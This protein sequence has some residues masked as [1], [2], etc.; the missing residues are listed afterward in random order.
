[1]S[2]LTRSFAALR[3]AAA[4]RLSRVADGLAARLACMG[5]RPARR[6]RTVD[7]LTP[8]DAAAA[9]RRAG[10]D[11]RAEGVR[12][13]LDGLSPL[14]A[15]EGRR[16]DALHALGWLDDM[17]AADPTARRALAATAFDWLRRHGDGGAGW[18]PDLAGRRLGALAAAWP[19]LDAQGDA[20]DRRRL[21]RAIDAHLRFLLRRAAAADAPLRRLEAAAGLT[22]GAVAAGEDAHARRGAALAGAAADALIDREGGAADRSPETLARA[23]ALAAWATEALQAAGVDPEPRL[24]AALGRAAPALRALRMGDGGLPRL[25][26]AARAADALADEALARAGAIGRGLRRAEAAGCAR[27]AAGRTIAILDAAPPP[28]G[29]AGCA[30]TLALEVSVGRTR[31][32]G[33]IGTGRAMSADWATAARATAAHSAVEVAGASSARLAPDGWA[34]RILGRPLV[35]G[36][37]AAQAER[38]EDLDGRWLL[39][40]HDGYLRRFGVVVARRLF[41]SPDGRDLRGED[42]LSCPDATARAAFQR[43]AKNGELPFCVRFHLGPGVAAE[44]TGGAVALR[45]P[46]GARWRV[47]CS[48]GQ[49]EVADSVR[50]DAGEP[51]PAALQVVATSRARDYWGRVI[52]RFREV[53][54]APRASPAADGRRRREPPP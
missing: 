43:A 49:L 30:S 17:L 9:A 46:D 36:P 18:R 41:L 23:A 38:V 28:P 45:L 48:G 54:P 26:G 20:A 31:L 13:R 12:G 53:E 21:A 52:W 50:L 6:A 35:A 39:A 8:G 5:A 51:P 11:W 10:G 16:A 25:H 15:A 37:T 47:E 34:A 3:R 14:A 44:R 22:V 4:R 19:L 40:E 2:A 24:A 1:M 27:L 7:P 33:G 29:P 32:F 42:S